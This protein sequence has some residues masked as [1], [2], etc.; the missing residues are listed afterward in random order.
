[1]TQE[2]IDYAWS[3]PLPEAIVKAGKTFVC[4]YLAKL[5]NGKVISTTELHALLG[6]GISVV[7]NWEQA[8]GDMLKGHSTG[9]EHAQEAARQLA[10]LGVPTTIPVYFSCDVNITTPTQMNAVQQYLG[11]AASVLGYRRV[12]VYG[13]A[14]VIDACVPSYAMWGWQTYA[15]SGGRISGKAHLYQY[16]NGVV[17]GGVDVDLDRSL[18]DEFG[19]LSPVKGHHDMLSLIGEL[20]ELNHGDNDDLYDGYRNVTRVQSLLVGVWS[21]NI[22]ID[23]VYGDATA[24]AVREVLDQSTGTDGQSIGLAEW[25]ILYGI[26]NG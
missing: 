21:K 8:A 22:L 7:F 4:R 6:A 19:A 1:M 5:P 3:K 12:G 25:R 24:K 16:R 15:W 26:T 10:S 20:P 11:G 13:E 23:G 17:V 9:A 18:R 2:G 14:D